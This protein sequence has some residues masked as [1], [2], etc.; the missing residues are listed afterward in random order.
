MFFMHFAG[1]LNCFEFLKKE[2]IAFFWGKNGVQNIVFFLFAKY[3]FFGVYNDYLMIVQKICGTHGIML[4][5]GHF[6]VGPLD[7]S[8]FRSVFQ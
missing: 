5:D 2:I 1:F 6:L 7:V 8:W 3:C 4:H